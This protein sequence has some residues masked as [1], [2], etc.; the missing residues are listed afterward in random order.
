MAQ[1]KQ[2]HTLF[3]Y[4]LTITIQLVKKIQSSGLWAIVALIGFY[5]LQLKR[6]PYYLIIGVPVL[7]IGIGLLINSLWSIINIF[8]PRVNK[9]LCPLCNKD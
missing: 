5:I 6:S 3:H 7:L 4:L 9:A 8:S 2:D 1:K